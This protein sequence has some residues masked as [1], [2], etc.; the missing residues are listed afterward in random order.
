MFFSAKLNLE[1]LSRRSGLG[2]PPIEGTLRYSA[3]LKWVAAVAAVAVVIVAKAAV[4]ILEVLGTLDRL[5]RS[6][7]AFLA[8]DLHRSFTLGTRRTMRSPSVTLWSRSPEELLAVSTVRSV[9][10]LV[11]RRALSHSSEYPYRV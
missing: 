1:A 3:R 4:G 2:T 8:L 7:R 9:W 5:D 11:S 6:W 10:R